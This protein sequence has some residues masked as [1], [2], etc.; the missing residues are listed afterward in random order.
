[1]I[2]AKTEKNLDMIYQVE[3]GLDNFP[4]DLG[5]WPGKVP[6]LMRSFWI[7][8]GSKECQYKDNGFEESAVK[9]LCESH[10]C[11]CTLSLFT[12]GTY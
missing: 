1:M 10:R 8:R 3:E 11:Y 6:E 2:T 5:N 7:E 4:I 12:K 9:L